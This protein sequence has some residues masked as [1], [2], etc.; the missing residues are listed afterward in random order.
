MREKSQF[1]RRLS[2]ADDMDEES[3]GKK[4]SHRQANENQSE[5]NSARK[6]LAQES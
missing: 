4:D 5:M 2:E 1:A 3:D 6:S